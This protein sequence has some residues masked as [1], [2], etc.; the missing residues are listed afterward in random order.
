MKLELFPQI[1]DIQ[2]E[3]KPKMAYSRDLSKMAI[4]DYHG[5]TRTVKD[6]QRLS[7]MTVIDD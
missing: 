3:N 1:L 5:L 4:E 2:Y 6:Y 7:W